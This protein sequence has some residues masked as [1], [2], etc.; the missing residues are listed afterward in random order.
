MEYRDVLI[1]VL[2]DLDA[3]KVPD[4][5]REVAFTIGIETLIGGPSSLPPQTT[6]APS[7]DLTIPARGTAPAGDS[8]G[9]LLAS[10]LGVSYADVTDV[11]NFGGD[12]DPE[13]VVGSGKLPP[14]DAAATKEIAVLIAAARQGTGREEWTPF[15]EI[16]STCAQYGRLDTNNF[17]ST[18]KELETYFSFRS[19]SPRKREV[20]LNRPGWERATALVTRLVEG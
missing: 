1:K 10:R 12:Q 11:F 17:A 19:P 2:E 14:Q 5:L 18:M 6:Q 3:A 9:A 4:G 13:L 8:P 16:R 20:K 15:S 7:L